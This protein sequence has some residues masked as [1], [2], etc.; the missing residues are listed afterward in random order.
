MHRTSTSLQPKQE[1]GNR[2]HSI[3]EPE[4]DP[5]PD[6][7][8]PIVITARNLL[9]QS[10]GK[11]KNNN[12]DPDSDPD[13]DPAPPVIISAD[14]LQAP[15]QEPKLGPQAA[16]RLLTSTFQQNS[17]NYRSNRYNL[18]DLSKNANKDPNPDPDPNPE[19][20]PDPDPAPPIIISRERQASGSPDCSSNS[21][22][23]SLNMG[24][25]ISKA[26]EQARGGKL[27]SSVAKEDKEQMKEPKNY[28]THRS[29]SMRRKVGGNE[30]SDQG[31]GGGLN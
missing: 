2:S 7:A 5:D 18:R 26:K 6:P 24:S 14:S 21:A 13:P 4:P 30:V 11:R 16:P 3:L 31:S 28:Y 22:P 15:I 19:P 27:H 1:K 10:K 23:S 17:T 25:K 29:K 20:E 8:P 12:P 9:N